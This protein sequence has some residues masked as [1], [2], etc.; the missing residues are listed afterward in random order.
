MKIGLTVRHMTKGLA[1]RTRLVL[2]THSTPFYA[3]NL[4]G[5][6]FAGMSAASK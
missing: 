5:A 3:V 4:I 1:I 6:L 2:V